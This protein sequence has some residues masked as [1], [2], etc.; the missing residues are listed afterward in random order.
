MPVPVI[1]IAM[2]ALALFG[3]AAS[4]K[5][6]RRKARAVTGRRKRDGAKGKA[7]P[8]KKANRK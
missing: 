7:S 4:R 8:K 1:P 5:D 6:V 3:L 2:G